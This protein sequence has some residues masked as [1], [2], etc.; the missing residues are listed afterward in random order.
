MIMATLT[1]LGNT[2]YINTCIQ[3]LSYTEELNNLLGYFAP[4]KIY[5]PTIEESCLFLGVIKKAAGSRNLPRKSTLDK[6]IC[7]GLNI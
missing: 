7:F 1:N 5:E 2:C 6:C 3:I 4:E